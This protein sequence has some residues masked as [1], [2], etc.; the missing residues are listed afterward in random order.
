MKAGLFDD[1]CIVHERE[2]E[3]KMITKI[4]EKCHYCIGYAEQLD[5]GEWSECYYLKGYD[6]MMHSGYMTWNELRHFASGM[7]RALWYM[8]RIDK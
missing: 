2:A 4:L 1:T 8:G 7:S 5:C 3:Y 6:G